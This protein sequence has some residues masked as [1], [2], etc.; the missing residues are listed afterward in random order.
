MLSFVLFLIICNTFLSCTCFKK[1]F[2][3]L[4]IYLAEARLRF[5]DIINRVAIVGEHQVKFIILFLSKIILHIVPNLVGLFYFSFQNVKYLELKKEYRDNNLVADSPSPQPSSLS[6]DNG[7]SYSS[8]LTQNFQPYWR[9]RLST[10]SRELNLPVARPNYDIYSK[11]QANDAASSNIERSV[12]ESTL[13]ESINNIQP[14]PRTRG[15]SSSGISRS[16]STNSPENANPHALYRN[17]SFTGNEYLSRRS[18]INGYPPQQ[19]S[20]DLNNFQQNS[21]FYSPQQFQNQ[22]SPIDTRR[23]SEVF[24]PERPP[25]SQ[26]PPS[27]R[28]EFNKLNSDNPNLS[29][30]RSFS[31]SH[32][33]LPSYLSPQEVQHHSSINAERWKEPRQFITRTERSPKRTGIC[34]DDMLREL[35]EEEPPKPSPECFKDFYPETIKENR[36]F[37]TQ[38]NG[39]NY[40]SLPEYPY[41][42]DQPNDL[43]CSI[44]NNRNS[45]E[46]KPL[47]FPRNEYKN[48]TKEL[49]DVKRNL[50]PNDDDQ[51][52]NHNVNLSNDDSSS[53]YNSVNSY[54]S[55]SEKE[56]HNTSASI[57]YAKMS[58]DDAEVQSAVKPEIID[59]APPVPPERRRKGSKPVIDITNEEEP[60][61]VKVNI[62]YFPCCNLYECL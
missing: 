61:S 1:T 52:T 45:L 44:S 47:D 26:W 39:E 15:R 33:S 62:L 50:F 27:S 9:Y 4:F 20:P 28:R 35:E 18:S 42:H 34:S 58:F 54:S 25:R 53:G 30:S 3:C 16:I 24:I 12:S 60:K 51:L 13:S 19:I 22:S 11:V 49:K 37:Y 56:L 41:N 29:H 59:S 43:N 2:F 23:H 10:S 32:N 46:N 57:N 5:K 7:S 48:E 36:N 31:G 8:P 17:S 55:K 21:E 40:S 38:G 6:S 14:P